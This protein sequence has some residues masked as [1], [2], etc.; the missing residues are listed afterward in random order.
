[1]LQTKSRG[2]LFDEV[3]LT[4]PEMNAFD[5]SHER[6]LTCRAGELNVSDIIETMPADYF[7]I[8]NQILCRPNPMI[9]PVMQRIS[10]YQHYF[11]VPNRIVWEHWKDFISRGDGKVKFKDAANYVP[12]EPP[13]ITASELLELS[14]TTLPNG[15]KVTPR[16]ANQ[17][18]IP[19][20]SADTSLDGIKISILPF[21][22]FALIYNEYYR[23]ENLIEEI[24]IEN[25]QDLDGH[26]DI[27]NTEVRA[28][29]V[30]IFK[31]HFRC[32]EKDYFTSALPE[33]Q[34]GPD[35]LL[36]LSFSGDMLLKTDLDPMTLQPD[37]TEVRPL[38]GAFGQGSEDAIR[39]FNENKYSVRSNFPGFGVDSNG[40]VVGEK[41]RMHTGD[42]YTPSTDKLTP[43][44]VSVWSTDLKNQ[45]VRY[46]V[47][48]FAQ[49]AVNSY[50]Q[51]YANSPWLSSQGRF[52]VFGDTSSISVSSATI[53][54]VRRAFALQRWFEKAARVGSRYT[55]T[56]KGFFNVDVG[57]DTLQRPQFIGGFS[58][59]ITI[60]EVLQTSEST[61]NS[62]QGNFSGHGLSALESET[63][64]YTCREHGFIISVLSV[65]PRTSYNQGL[66]RY[67]SR[68]TW[69][70]Y[71]WQEFA[72]IGE[73]EVRSKELYLQNPVKVTNGSVTPRV[74]NSN[75]DEIFGYQSRYSEYKYISDDVCGDFAF[76]L[77][78]WHLNRN[79]QSRP[80]LS[81][82]FVE[83]H[84]SDRIFAV[85]QL[86]YDEQREN[87]VIGEDDY[88]VDIWF[89]VKVMRALPLYSDPAM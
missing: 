86:E 35:V 36:P 83:A 56:I 19:L 49:G 17:M 84:A 11:F 74:G 76:N 32:W 71:P 10:L 26:L 66:P 81:Q 64:T 7:E 53:V 8:Q 77:D 65:L 87:D 29:L 15:V 34:R 68:T 67:F 23:D 21:V 28:T 70:D 40:Y 27:S 18:R 73:Q 25:I 43:T 85:S 58:S 1:M 54:E 46:G 38:D 3:K 55:E 45:F 39:A 50:N 69:L 51:L 75:P 30:D 72:L 80:E 14:S 78:Y 9:A 6:R 20:M 22:A 89:D 13:Y 57:D 33:P 24:G 88:L 12:P 42:V 52:R 82:A 41:Y 60:S 79:F 2:F 48:D 4:T 59:P 16:L 31:T 61:Q 37:V 47:N 63:I 5:I 44:G 62:P